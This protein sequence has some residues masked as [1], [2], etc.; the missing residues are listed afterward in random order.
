MTL[1]IN[2]IN[3]SN[4]T[5]ERWDWTTQGVDDL[6]TVNQV[7]SM[8]LEQK[9]G[10]TTAQVTINVPMIEK[11]VR[12]GV[13]YSCN[14]NLF[15]VRCSTHIQ[16]FEIGKGCTWQ[17]FQAGKWEDLGENAAPVTVSFPDCRVIATPVLT[18]ETATVTVEITQPDKLE[19][20]TITAFIFLDKSGRN[21]RWVLRLSNSGQE[22]VFQNN[23]DT[24]VKKFANMLAEDE[25][26]NI[27]DCFV[28]ATD[29]AI[30]EGILSITNAVR[31][32]DA[33]VLAWEGADEDTMLSEMETVGEAILE[34]L[35]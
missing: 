19:A 11:D 25:I 29:E 24:G 14:G 9:D 34:F 13:G 15:G 33:A 18:H 22:Y 8:S 4:L 5:W 28:D 35:P 1:T 17:V 7:P 12:I 3:F 21:D 26:S 31:M 30:V 10:R 2:Y 27:G 32:G 23:I 6:V 20:A 16:V